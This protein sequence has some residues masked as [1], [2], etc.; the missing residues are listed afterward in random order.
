MRRLILAV[1][2]TTFVV[3]A[4]P[5]PEAEARLGTGAIVGI[6]VAAAALGAIIGAEIA[7]RLSDRD[8]A[9]LSESYPR[10]YEAPV[11]QPIDWRGD[12][13]SG[14]MIV[15]RTGYWA[16]EPTTKCREVRNTIYDSQGHELENE[17]RTTCQQGSQWVW[18]EN[19]E[20]VE[21]EYIAPAPRPHPV[22]RPMHSFWMSWDVLQHKYLNYIRD[23]RTSDDDRL[24]TVDRIE[25]HLRDHRLHLS[26]QQLFEILAPIRNEEQRLEAL[27]ILVKF[28]RYKPSDVAEISNLFFRCRTA[29]I[30][31]L[32]DHR[33]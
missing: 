12:T 10:I 8:E 14:R 24:D 11:G 9:A 3:Q 16:K 21:G 18:V 6:G 15:L 4:G 22:P 32:R 28:A 2:A 1:V 31:I 29:A 26:G 27:E 20:M 33:R 19:S 30:G 5:Q 25:D 7:D 13:C 17:V 23:R